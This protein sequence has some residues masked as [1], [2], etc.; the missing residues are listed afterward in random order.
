VG[1]VHVEVEQ[2]GE[3]FEGGLGQ[4][5]GLVTDENGVLLLAL[6]E[7]HDGVG[8]LARQIAAVVRRD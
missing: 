6:I 5:L 3:L 2:Q 8:D 4:E 1:G 7:A